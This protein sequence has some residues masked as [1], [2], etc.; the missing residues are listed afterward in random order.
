MRITGD[1]FIDLVSFAI[2]IILVIPIK[3]LMD[4]DER[5]TEK[6]RGEK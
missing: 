6:K 2:C 5:R 3:L 1:P 4:W